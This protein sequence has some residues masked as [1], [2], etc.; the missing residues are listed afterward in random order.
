MPVHEPHLTIASLLGRG[1]PFCSYAPVSESVW[2]E[3]VEVASRSGLG[4]LTLEALDSRGLEH[5]SFSGVGSSAAEPLLGPGRSRGLKHAARNAK[6]GNGPGTPA[7]VVRQLRV[8]AQAVARRNIRLTAQLEPVLTA[9]H[10]AN[11]PVMLLKGA[12]LNVTV[13]AT[14]DLR[15]M[16]DVDL[17]VRQAD[18][19]RAVTVLKRAGCHEGM[20]LLR[21]DFFPTYYYETE[22][23]S[24][25]PKP[26]RIDLHA[27]PLRP[28][29]YAQ[30]IPEA[31]FWRDARPAVVGQS[32]A[33]IPSPEVMFVH[34]AAHAAFHGCSRLIWLY[35]LKRWVDTHAASIN[36]P[37]VVHLCAAWHVSLAVARATQCAEQRFGS[38]VPA[39]AL[40]A[41]GA[42]PTNLRDRLVLHE[43]PQDAG[44]SWRAVGTNL[45]CT[46]GWRFRAGY[47]W[48]LLRPDR[49]HL[50]GL[51][52]HRHPGWL[53]V[54][55]LYRFVR[56]CGRLIG[57]LVRRLPLV[58]HW[59]DRTRP[60]TGYAPPHGVSGAVDTPGR[61]KALTSVC[62]GL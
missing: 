41:L 31:S 39:T 53:M 61:L 8:S 46:P 17:L 38:L 28:L 35:D 44:S 29:R 10:E 49:G 32:H 16:S 57:G 22:L 18:A 51:Y 24:N 9:L 26:L 25:D 33:M 23:L 15:P 7:W 12:A 59:I 52:P 60:A 30:I 54:A 5:C 20:S 43:A 55:R 6:T 50:A 4:G 14:P 58:A 36:W 11:I 37:R 56:A 40:E 13:Y 34:L 47:L 45:L 3:L 27:R 21:D 62:P 19:R 1:A 48:A 2:G 42:G